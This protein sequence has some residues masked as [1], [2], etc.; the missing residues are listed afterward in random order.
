MP[1]C[2]GFGFLRH[3]DYGDLLGIFSTVKKTAI[4]LVFLAVLFCSRGP[5]VRAGER[6]VAQVNGE[7]LF[8][9]ELL[10]GMPQPGADT[11]AWQESKRTT[12]ERMI[13]KTLI[14]QLARKLDYQDSISAPLERQKGGFVREVLRQNA[15]KH[16][17]VTP[18]DVA[19]ESLLLSTNIHLKLIEVTT[20]DTAQMVATRLKNGVPFESLAVRYSRSRAAPPDGDMGFWLEAKVPPEVM[21]ALKDLKPGEATGLVVRDVFYDFV[22]YEGERTAPAES[23]NLDHAKLE[24][25]AKR[26]KTEEYLR[27]LRNRVQYDERVLDYLT[28]NPDSVQPTDAET[29]VARLPDGSQTRVG[30]L[31]PL[32]KS[33]GDVLSSAR[34]KALKEYIENGV[35]EGEARRLKLDQTPEY[36]AQLKYLTDRVLYEFCVERQINAPSR[37]SDSEVSAY[38]HQH[39]ESF[40][41]PEL[42]P[43]EATN[44]RGQLTQPRQ[45]EIAMTLLAELRKS[46]TITIDEKLLAAL[47]PEKAAK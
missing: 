45:Q 21:D 19:R 28:A 17:V 39:S 7:K 36:R 13:D 9:S 10:T 1:S 2:F 24:S 26:R 11:Q 27:G 33:Y 14:L 32:V 25:S 22:K 43:D 3:I 41:T 46:A 8:A 40:P 44:I 5:S 12:L 29:V 18:A 34:R 47:K 42:T 16:V 23:V 30:S 37:A 4:L 20:Y 35:L 31:L 38:F 6:V 15:P